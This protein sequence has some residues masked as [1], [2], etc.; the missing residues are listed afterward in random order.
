MDEKKKR[1]TGRSGGGKLSGG[2]V[3]RQALLYGCIAVAVMGGWFFVQTRDS[4]PPPPPDA[5]GKKP[6]VPSSVEAR[7]APEKIE[8]RQERDPGESPEAGSAESRQVL[9][10]GMDDPSAGAASEEARRD[11]YYQQIRMFEAEARETLPIIG[12][13]SF[14]PL[15]AK[16]RVRTTS[17]KEASTSG[18]AQ[19]TTTTSTSSASEETA[20]GGGDSESAGSNAALEDPATEDEGETASGT[21]DLRDDRGLRDGEVWIR[22]NPGNSNEFR[23]VMAQTADLYRANTDYTGDVTV[24]LWVGGQVMA[25]EVY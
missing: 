20:S 1:A 25:K 17:A 10:L 19:G 9:R 3:W 7:P 24:L 16:P 14:N 13:R 6:A 5:T 2:S 15:Q 11:R 12:M 18:R 8:S 23:E 22:I 21:G 4:S